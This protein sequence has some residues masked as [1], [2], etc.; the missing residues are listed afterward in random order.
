[1]TYLLL[2]YFIFAWFLPTIYSYTGK[3]LVFGVE[4]LAAYTGYF[5]A[6]YYFA[7]YDLTP[8]QTRI[9]YISGT[10]LL[11]LTV[12]VHLA[13][14]VYTG[15]SMFPDYFLYNSFNI[16]IVAFFIFV[17]VKNTINKSKRI[18]EKYQDNKYINLF[19]GCSFGIYLTHALFL[20][21]IGGILHINT[22]TFP[23]IISVPVLAIVT[24]FCAFALTYFIK[25]IPVLG[26]WIV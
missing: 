15:G 26:K 7:K 13:M 24:Y 1:M 4:G 22:S 17:F 3:G 25:K 6:G 16:A 12:I 5:I 18:Q 23:A 14:S 8:L 2:L 11:L 21:V 20:N 10:V 19:S 9:L